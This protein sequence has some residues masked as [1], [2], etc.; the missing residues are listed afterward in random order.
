MAEFS[1]YVL[2]KVLITYTKFYFIPTS[3]D[4]LDNKKPFSPNMTLSNVLSDTEIGISSESRAA[5]LKI[6]ILIDFGM[7]NLKII[8]VIC[9]NETFQS[10][11]WLH[12]AISLK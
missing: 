3:P 6:Y 11:G 8:L 10:Y 2:S 9:K 12:N 7:G 5:M 1:V 4:I